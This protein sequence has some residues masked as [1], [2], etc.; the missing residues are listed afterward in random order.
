VEKVFYFLGTRCLM[1]HFLSEY[2]CF[3]VKKKLKFGGFQR[4]KLRYCINVYKYNIKIGILEKL[5]VLFLVKD[6]ILL[7]HVKK[8]KNKLM[9]LIFSVSSNNFWEHC[10][11]VPLLFPPMEEGSK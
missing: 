1:E 7:N 10:S 2:W 3:F 6:Y 8:S 5:L 11:R 9:F 4:R